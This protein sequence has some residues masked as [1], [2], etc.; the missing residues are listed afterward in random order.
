MFAQAAP[1]GS[2]VLPITDRGDGHVK[3]WASLAPD[4]TVRFVL[5][6]KGTS[7]SRIVLPR[8]PRFLATARVEQLR[9]RGLAARTGVLL[10]GQTFGDAT[11]SGALSPPLAAMIHAGSGTY[12]M[13]LPPASATMLTVCQAACGPQVG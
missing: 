1:P 2:R 10:G 12:V 6:N 5:I 11:A 3:G 8:L 13:T 7:R 4:Q 9:A